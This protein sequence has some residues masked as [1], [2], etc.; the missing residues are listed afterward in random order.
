MRVPVLQ[1]WTLQKTMIMK[2][3]LKINQEMRKMMIRNHQTS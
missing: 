2:T 1:E 3:N